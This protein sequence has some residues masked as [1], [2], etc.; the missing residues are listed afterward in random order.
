MIIDTD[1]V[2]LPGYMPPDKLL[3]ALDKRVS[4]RESQ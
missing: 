3:E 2:A 1:G 4:M